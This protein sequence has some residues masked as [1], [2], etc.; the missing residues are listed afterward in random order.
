MS[1]T[2]R[3]I[4]AQPTIRERTGAWFHLRRL[5]NEPFWFGVLLLVVG[6]FALF[7]LY[8]TAKMVGAPSLSDWQRFFRSA[9]FIR[10]FKNTILSSVYAT[11]TATILGFVFAYAMNYTD[12]PG[13]KFFRNIVLL[14]L[15]SP[16]AVTGLAF[17][18]L[19]GRRG[20]ITHYILGLNVDMYGPVGLWIVQSLS[21]FPVAYVAISGVLRAIQPNL[22]LAARNLGSSGFHLFRTVTLP[23]AL[24][25][26]I[27]AAL[28]VGISALADFGNPMLIGGNYTVLATEA[29]VQATG[30]WDLNMASVL[31]MMLVL[32]TLL[33]FMFQKFYLDKRSFV[34]IT[35][36]PSSQLMRYP[37]SNLV[38]VLIFIVCAFLSLVILLLYST[39]V[40]GAFTEVLGVQNIFT[41]SHFKRAV[42]HSSTLWNSWILGLCAA[43]GTAVLGVLIAYLVNR[44][45]FPGRGLIDF[46]TL[47]PGSLP[48]TF[49]GI[50]LVMAFNNEPFML[51]GTAFILVLAMGLRQL[52]VAYRNAYAALQQIDTSIEQAAAN[53]GA[54]GFQTFT[55]IVLPMLKNAFSSGLV[56]NFMKSMNTLSAVIFLVSPRWT[57]GAVSILSLADHGYTG[58]AS[59]IAFGMI[60]L[61]F[62]TL[63][64]AKLIFK[65]ALNIF[66]I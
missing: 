60:L 26:V 44:K 50:S 65:D 4:Q 28:L 31:S 5:A 1:N 9:R 43:V 46:L 15:M 18:L 41:L 17:L 38:R 30:R 40:V 2:P 36:K 21:F 7:I 33:L 61:V 63:G 20:F 45:K 57:L 12:I 59:A 48:G 29:Y 51:T 58:Q 6:F 23:L 42:F 35:G 11:V 22:E 39:I 10:A 56:Y 25:G 32:P 37:V 47:L 49:I 54:N 14:P 53:L 52:P 3:A 13:K 19:F 55:G 62:A 66:D 8:P 27:S 64:A 34:T 24:P 16:P